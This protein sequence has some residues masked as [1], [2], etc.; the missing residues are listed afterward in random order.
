M[1]KGKVSRFRVKIGGYA[2]RRA[3]LQGRTSSPSALFLDKAIHEIMFTIFILH[4]L[5]LKSK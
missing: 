5:V 1:P 2:S 4:N 3:L